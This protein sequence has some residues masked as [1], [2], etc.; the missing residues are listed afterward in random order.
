MLAP[1]SGWTVPRQIILRRRF[2]IFRE[3]GHEMIGAFPARVLTGNAMVAGGS[4]ASPL[5]E[6][7]LSV[8]DSTIGAQR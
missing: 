6:M 5:G 7:P 3:T 4:G 2:D 1:A 8:V